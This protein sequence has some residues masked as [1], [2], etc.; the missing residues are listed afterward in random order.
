LSSPLELSI[1]MPCL[2]EAETLATCIRKAQGSLGRLGIVGEVIVA[3]NG[4]RDASGHRGG[5]RP[6]RD[7]GRGS[8]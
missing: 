2:N 5:R 8:S 3:D 6:L 4:S 7:H 1:V